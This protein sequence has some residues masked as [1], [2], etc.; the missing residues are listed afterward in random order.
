MDL[1]PIH[2]ISIIVII[3][4]FEKS[5]IALYVEQSQKLKNGGRTFCALKIFDLL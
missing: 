5:N 2:L 4:K 3:V 1:I